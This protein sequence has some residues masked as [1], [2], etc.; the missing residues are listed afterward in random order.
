MLHQV[1]ETSECARGA[2][3]ALRQFHRRQMGGAG[4]RPLFRQYQPDH[5]QAGLPDRPLTSGRHRARARRGAQGQGRLG[6]HRARQARRDPEQDRRPHGGEPLGARRGRDHRQRQADPRDELRRHPARHRPFPLFRG[7]HPRPGRLAVSEIDH[8]TVAYH[9]HEPLG[10]VG[11][12]H[13]V[14]LPDPD[15]VA[16]SSR[17]LSPPAIASC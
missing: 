1:I 16:G 2:A 11:A 9:Y 4:R 6:Q 15:G 10:V 13:P 3:L 14:E 17:R 8:D 7:L 5:R 12:D